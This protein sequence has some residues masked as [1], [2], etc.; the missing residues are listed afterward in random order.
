M[1]D[2]I[3]RE[4][5]ILEID[6]LS[7]KILDLWEEA[8]TETYDYTQKF[9]S[10]RRVNKLDPRL[11]ACLEALNDAASAWEEIEA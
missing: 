5:A 7:A 3:K 6:E 8:T 4:Q 11:R 2:E 1:I 9:R 10:H